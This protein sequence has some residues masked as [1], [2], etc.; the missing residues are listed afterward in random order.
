MSLFSSLINWHRGDIFGYRGGKKVKLMNEFWTVFLLSLLPGA[1]NFIGGM[2]AECWKPSPRFLNWSLHAASGIVVAIVAIA[3]MP[4]AL[5]ILAGWWIALAFISGGVAYV[6]VDSIVERFQAG[7]SGDNRSRMWMIYAAVAVDLVSDGMMLGTGAAVSSSLALVLAAGQMLADLPEGYATV[8]NFRDK[9][10]ARR[11]RILLSASFFLFII[12]AACVSYLFLHDASGSFK[13]AIL[14][15]VAGLLLVAA[16]EAMLKEA[17]EA[18]SD[19][20][21]SVLAF[22][23]G[24]TLF[25]LVSAGLETIVD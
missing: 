9:G 2:T 4:E 21:R 10:V 22:V 14:V 18:H 25:V 3:L 8:A 11:R 20:R 16:I 17:H 1:G 7:P 6:A 13:A 19:S 5:G 23:G 15:F 24:F 12:G